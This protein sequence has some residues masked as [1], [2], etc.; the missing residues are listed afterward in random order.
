M[1]TFR[2]RQICEGEP[3]R[4]LVEYPCR[5]V[6]QIRRWLTGFGTL[7]SPAGLAL[8]FGLP[9]LSLVLGLVLILVLPSDYFVRARPQGGLA[10]SHRPLRVLMFWAKNTA[11]VLLLLAGFVMALPLVPGPGLLVMLIGL[12]LVD[13]PGKRTLELRLLRE[14]HVLSSVN[15]IRARFGKGPILSSESAGRSVVDSTP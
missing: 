7:R 1:A 8:A 12:G 5:V 11:G 10:G 13:F 15:R 4:G 6:E 2:G 3:A 14:Q 9:T